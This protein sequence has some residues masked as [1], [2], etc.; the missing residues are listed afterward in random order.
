MRVAILQYPIYWAD[1]HANLSAWAERI[2][3][4]RGQADVALLPEMC[5]SGFCTDRP[6]LAEPENG[7]TVA[8]MQALADEADLMVVGSYICRRADGRLVN[9]GF[10][11]RPGM[12]PVYVD[13]RHLYQAE[14]QYFSAGDQRPVIEWRGVRFRYIICYDLRF[15]VWARQDKAD[16]YDILLVSANWPDSR[17]IDWDVLVAARGTENQA[18]IAACNTVGTDGLGLRYN[19]HS[20]A[21]DSRHQSLAR[22]AD[23]ESGTRIADFD[24]AALRH[25]REVVPL[26]NDAD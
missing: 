18:Y 12:E 7:E 9:R 8:F 26:W 4:L 24:I 5:T 23:G 19:G 11:L 2:R 20:V 1:K 6:E 3:A 15:P 16:L 22:W 21:Y 25:Y 17:I 13:K 10:M 14:K